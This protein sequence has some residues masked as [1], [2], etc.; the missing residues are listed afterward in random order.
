MKEIWEYFQVF[1]LSI[2]PISEVRGAIPYGIVALKLRALPVFLIS[3]LGNLIVSF[4]LIFIW[5]I[6]FLFLSSR[7]K[8]FKK[9]FEWLFDKTRKRFSPY[10]RKWQDI[11]LCF[12]VAIPLPFTGAWTGSLAAFLFG[13][14]R[15]EALISISFGVLIASILILALTLFGIELERFFGYKTLSLLILTF[16]FAWIILK[17]V[18]KK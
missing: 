1:F 2:L 18:V 5:E 16:I 17:K 8:L 14:K 11:G 3:L 13:I 12:F 7:F 15:K 9:F 6:L 10:Y 4:F